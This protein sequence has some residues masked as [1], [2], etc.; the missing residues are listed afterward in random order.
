MIE[1]RGQQQTDGLSASQTTESAWN[2]GRFSRSSLTGVPSASGQ[3]TERS[4][5]RRPAGCSTD[6]LPR[7][8]VEC[9]LVRSV[10]QSSQIQRWPWREPISRR[11]RR[12]TRR[13]SCFQPQ[14]WQS[15][16]GRWEPEFSTVS[17]SS[18]VPTRFIALMLINTGHVLRPGLLRTERGWC[19]RPT[20]V[21]REGHL[22]RISTY[23]VENTPPPRRGQPPSPNREERVQRNGNDQC[24]GLV[25]PITFSSPCRR[26]R[27]GGMGY[28]LMGLA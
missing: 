21:V 19:E 25:P 22:S 5:A 11:S 26:V 14:R 1:A 9:A 4:S 20:R 2:P 12:P 8:R 16:I 27:S 6:P 3:A 23:L 7:G 13:N 17:G 18:R 10:M 15:A 28:L 24:F